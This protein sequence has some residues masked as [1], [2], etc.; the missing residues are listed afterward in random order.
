M[1]AAEVA[2]AHYRD[3]V[4]LARRTEAAVAALW[5]R[6]DPLRILLSWLG[7]A[8]AATAIV[9]RAQLEAASSADGYLDDV[10]AAQ[11]FDTDAQGVLVPSALAGFASDGR[12]LGSLLERPA[13]VALQAIKQGATVPQALG[14]GEVSA[15]LI[16]STQVADAGRV[17]DGVALTAHHSVG[18]FYRMLNLPSCSR[19]V[20]LAGKWYRWNA[21][22]PRHPKCDCLHIPTREDRLD[23]VRTDPKQYFESLSRG[24]QD[25]VFTQAGAEAIRL[26]ADISQVVNARRGAAGI[27]YAAGRL[28]AAER[29]M[30]RGGRELGRLETRRVFGRNV[31][32]TTEGTTTRGVAGVRLGARETGTKVPG[33]RYRT[34]KSPRLMPESILA[35]ANG[36]REEAIRLLRRFGYIL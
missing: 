29:E 19:C 8:P 34:A 11:G 22:F 30:L 21:G 17:A 6:V 2:S 9:A 7:L 20:V 24:E 1:D 31:F 10:L 32:T 27:G 23:E 18:G 25:K 28:T 15:R 16:A 33:S 3:R 26:G 35:E 36:N 4:A 12:D 14:A 13:V 5:S